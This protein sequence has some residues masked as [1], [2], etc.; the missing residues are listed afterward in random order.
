MAPS[1]KPAATANRLVKFHADAG[2]NIDGMFGTLTEVRG[3]IFPNYR[4][5]IRDFE[6]LED[7]RKA[8]ALASDIETDLK[9]VTQ[10]IFAIQKYARDLIEQAEQLERAAD[11]M[12]TVKN[13]LQ[14]AM[15]VARERK[16]GRR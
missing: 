16:A 1:T 6:Y 5:K 9:A 3:T 10:N 2:K 15:Y 8:Q 4:N 14:G 12:Y 13:D 7:E 11:S